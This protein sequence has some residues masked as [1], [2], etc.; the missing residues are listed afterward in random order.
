MRTIIIKI[1][2]V[3]GIFLS[4]FTCLAQTSFLDSLRS[5]I[6]T[7]T[8]TRERINALNRYSFE[9][10]NKNK[11]SSKIMAASALRQSNEISYYTGVGEACYN[12]GTVFYLKNNDS[13]LV[14]FKKSLQGYAKEDAGLLR[15]SRA[16]NGVTNV[17]MQL[18][19]YDS[20]I[21]Y[22]HFA[23]AYI[24]GSRDTS[25]IKRERLMYSY[26]ALGNAHYYAGYYD[27][28]IL[29]YLRA[30]EIGEKVKNYS[31]LNSYY[32]GIANI[33][34]TETKY[35]SAVFYGR[36]SA[37][38]AWA[39]KDYESLVL[40]LANIGGYYS[41]MDS[42]TQARVYTD[43]SL[44]LGRLYNVTRYEARNYTTLGTIEMHYHNCTNAL[45][46]FKTG[47]SLLEKKGSSQFARYVLLFET[48]KAYKCLD[49]LSLAKE[50]Y[51]LALKDG[52]GDKEH[53][54]ACCMGLS[55]VYLQEGDYKNA[56]SYLQKSKGLYDAVFSAEKTKI[57]NDLNT[58]YET[59]KKEQQL[60]ILANEKQLKEKEIARQQQQIINSGLLAKEQQQRIE[61]G[62][63][64]SEK[65]QQQMEIQ[66]LTLANNQEKL[67]KQELAIANTSNKLKVE[68]QQKEIQAATINT[69]KNRL[70]L[71]TVL[72][73]ASA[74]IAS[75][76]F[77][78]F[79]LNKKLESH[80]AL[81]NERLRISREL[82]DEVGA[83]LSGIAMYSHLTKT[84]MK[85]AQTAEVEKS[86]NIMQQSAGDMVNKLSDIVWLI[87]PGQ[88]S[89]QKLV[90]R[91]EEYAT[92]MA[93]IKNIQV[94]INFPANLAEHNLPVESRRNIYLFCKEA[95]NN[96]V[97]Y[98]QGTLLE[99]NVKE[100][101]DKLEFSVSDNGK[102]FDAVTVR[103]GNGL[104]NMQKRADEIGAKLL[105]QSKRE[106]GCF[107]SMQVK[108]V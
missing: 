79:K 89:L 52:E 97:K 93:M 27:S 45:A 44:N 41:R 74:I 60:I 1:I 9:L 51:L 49:S 82:H 36:K 78:R 103:R 39:V 68:Q 73:F 5:V 53:E 28:S 10:R 11:D 91:L 12:L 24:Q 54:A 64:L 2:L 7:S 65:Q 63:L 14:Y 102:G 105:L 75:L 23:L 56:Y 18:T 87:N 22:A 106:E 90:Q 104:E 30:A 34:A 107:V 92:D 43:S 86:L 21:Y 69:Q 15:V 70:L 81:M 16:Y 3:N 55:E 20:A 40:T 8:D 38:A 62:E 61:M 17:F 67:Q 58:R 96:A 32:L 13:A 42:F 84:Q 19:K 26:G 71:L 37:Q 98:S 25:A 33:N 77:G 48:G 59:E 100:T 76:F 72:V 66:G 47:L 88:D 99:L 94:K 4:S 29:Y 85:N 35:V 31:M 95:I 101:G 80:R 108:V 46:Y 83:T 57:I 50:N 6:N